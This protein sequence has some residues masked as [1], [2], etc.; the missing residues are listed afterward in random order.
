MSTHGD[1]SSRAVEALRA[2]RATQ[3]RGERSERAREVAG[4]L[5][6]LREHFLTEL[7]EPDWAGATYAYKRAV[8]EIYRSAGFTDISNISATV[9]YHI[10]NVLRERLSDDELEDAGLRLDTPRARSQAKRERTSAIL[11]ALRPIT[12]ADGVEVDP[13]RALVGAAS[14]LSR[15]QG[16]ALAAASPAQREHAA[17]QIRAVNREVRRL[18]AVLKR[19]GAPAGRRV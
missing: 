16:E 1:L 11:A 4:L 19:A 6:D 2:Y 9:R 14:L 15:V 8:G 12:D 18:S 3:D 5:V 7:G 13:I 10:G 17:E